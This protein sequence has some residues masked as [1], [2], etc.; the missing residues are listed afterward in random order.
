M[1]YYGESDRED[2][3]YNA[4]YESENRMSSDRTSFAYAIPNYGNSINS[5][6]IVLQ[7][8]SG[9]EQGDQGEIVCPGP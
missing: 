5:S 3:S 4:L 2:Q 9:Y 8:N 1:T 6:A 7:S